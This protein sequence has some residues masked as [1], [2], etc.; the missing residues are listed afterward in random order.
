MKFFKIAFFILTLSIISCDKKSISKPEDIGKNVFE[1]LKNIDKKT[2]ADYNLEVITYDELK[3][4]ANN[5]K[6]KLGD[7]RSEMQGMTSEKFKSLSLIHLHK[8]QNGGKKFNIDWSKITYSNFVFDIF[9][10]NIPDFGYESK[11]V[12]GETYFKNTD[13]KI[14]FVKS[15]SYY[16]GKGY[17]TVLVTE[18]DP[19]DRS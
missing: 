5:K 11:F 18:V 14:Y 7:S 13:G 15:I 4:L 1:L 19:K 17:K 3:A 16:D 6:A 12:K 10:S 2:V 9:D 8:I